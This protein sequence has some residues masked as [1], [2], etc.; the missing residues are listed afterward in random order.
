MKSTFNTPSQ[1]EPLLPTKGREALQEKAVELVRRASRLSGQVHPIVGAA[2]TDLL[3]AMNSYYSNLIEGHKT[4]PLSIE[5]ALNKKFDKDPG[6]KNLQQLALAHIRTQRAIEEKLRSS[7]ETPIA[8]EDFLRW[9]HREFYG[10]LPNEFLQLHRKD[11][12]LAERS[13]V[14][15]ELRSGEVEVGLHIPPSGRDLPLFLKRFSEAYDFRALLPLDRIIAAAAAHHRLAWVH[16]FDDGN[17]RV[18]RLFTDA[19]FFQEKLGGFGLWT[20]SRGLAR[21]RDGYYRH[22]AVADDLRKG[23]Y[24]GRG[25]LSDE[26]LS[27][28]CGFF[29]DVAL[30]QVQFMGGVLELEKVAARMESLFRILS[31]KQIIRFEAFYLMI[32]LFLKGEVSRGEASR[33][34][35]L[36]DST[37]REVVRF[38]SI[39]G[40]V[41]SDTPKSALKIKFGL[42]FAAYLFPT[43]YPENVD[44]DFRVFEQ[45]IA[46]EKK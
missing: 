6:K 3:R 12:T 36:G 15:G 18:M 31:D 38:L 46:Q 34:M 7:P 37:A 44:I 21:D 25:A 11:G 10:G 30:D 28:F 32:E 16:P 29:L 42:M 33:I 26:S 35:N 13:L 2:L 41:Q 43:L 24:D 27:D 1:M 39:L 14:P 9:V 40:F 23:D 5:A 17:G 45:K 22:L 8:T 20:I 19:F 4:H